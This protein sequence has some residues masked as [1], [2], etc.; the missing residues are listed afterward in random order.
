MRWGVVTDL[1]STA[2]SFVLLAQTVKPSVTD[3]P[4]GEV[5]F[6]SGPMTKFC[7]ILRQVRARDVNEMSA[8]YCTSGAVSFRSP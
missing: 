5:R 2:N 3:Y 6:I 1:K 4:I 7:D 8:M